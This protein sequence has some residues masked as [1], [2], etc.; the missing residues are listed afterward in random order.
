[1]TLR[2]LL[3]FAVVACTPSAAPSADAS[4]PAERYGAVMSEVGRR[5]ETA[6]RASEAHRFELAA[7]QA[8]EMQELFAEDLP[9]AELPKEGASGALPTMADAFLKTNVVDLVR[10]ADA[11][12]QRAFADA[13]ARAAAACNS[14]HQTSGHG[15]IEIPA[16]PGKAVPVV[17]PK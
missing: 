2:A 13:F 3:L 15:F 10:A 6:G 12:D 11:K 17:D 7:F 8:R 14:C 5:F 1:M 9:R 4:A 16:N